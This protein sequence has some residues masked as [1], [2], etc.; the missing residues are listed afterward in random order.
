MIMEAPAAGRY[1]EIA[2][3]QFAEAGFHGVSL[4]AIAKE[5]GVSKQAL[6]H[7]FGSKERLYGAVLKRLS[8]KLCAEVE[9]SNAMEPGAQLI[10]YFETLAKTSYGGGIE[11]KLVVRALLDTSETARFWPMKPYLD[12][13]TELAAQTPKWRGAPAEAIRAGLFQLIG[14]IQ[15]LSVSAI[16]LD[17][18]YG[19]AARRALELK[20][21]ENVSTA[22]R[23]FVEGG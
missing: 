12:K 2:E 18:M 8:D 7:F 13:L 3:R 6:L 9:S 11:A 1:L 4:A 17:G 10:E 15:Y 19:P 22:V 5:A 20:S 23:A 14:A 16:A 21:S